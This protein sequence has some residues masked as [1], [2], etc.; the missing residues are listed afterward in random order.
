MDIVYVVREIQVK[1]R[2]DLVETLRGQPL[3]HEAL[4]EDAE[5][6]V[7]G[8]PLAERLHA[9]APIHLL[10][11]LAALEVRLREA[12]LLLLLLLVSLIIDVGSLDVGPDLLEHLQMRVAALTLVQRLRIH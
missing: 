11:M 3:E 7:G 1:V 12:A 8:G 4:L 6:A 5:S 9:R 10:L 2:G